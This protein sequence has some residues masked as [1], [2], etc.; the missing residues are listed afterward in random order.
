MSLQAPGGFAEAGKG[1]MGRGVGPV[2]DADHFRSVV[3][4]RPKVAL[5]AYHEIP[6]MRVR[7]SPGGALVL[8]GRE[9][10]AA[11]L[12]LAVALLGVMR[13]SWFVGTTQ[14]GLQQ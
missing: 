13:L 10:K 2:A 6:R 12:G 3:V 9:G 11:T 8:M 1:G 7:P 14:G 4:R 5:R